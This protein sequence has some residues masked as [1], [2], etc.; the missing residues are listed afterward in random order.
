[1]EGNSRSFGYLAKT[2]SHGII[3]KSKDGDTVQLQQYSDASYATG[4]KGRSISG[5]ITLLD[6]TPLVWQSKQQTLVA[7]STCHAE[8]IAA[9]EATLQALPIQDL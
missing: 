9:Y 7:T 8:Y 6:G 1:M 3:I 4:S 2:L 5:R